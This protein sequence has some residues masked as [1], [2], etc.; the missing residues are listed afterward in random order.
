MTIFDE[1]K[2]GPDA[3]LDDKLAW[4]E[5]HRPPVRKPPHSGPCDWQDVPVASKQLNA[6]PDPNGRWFRRECRLCSR[7]YGFG[8]RDDE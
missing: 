1:M 7:F 3:R 2:P 6:K 5:R 4:I 8:V